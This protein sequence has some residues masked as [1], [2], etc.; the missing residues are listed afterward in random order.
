MPQCRSSIASQSPILIQ[1]LA[2]VKDNSAAAVVEAAVVGG[3]GLLVIPALRLEHD[4][5]ESCSSLE[6]A[7]TS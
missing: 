5:A 2:L 3:G 4:D 6:V 7:P 1:Q